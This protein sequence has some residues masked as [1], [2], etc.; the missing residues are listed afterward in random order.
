M[1]MSEK[2]EKEAKYFIENL[3]CMK[4]E[5]QKEEPSFKY[6]EILCK[7]LIRRIFEYSYI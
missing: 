1:R 2:Q 7:N 4:K 3:E 5:L 6:F